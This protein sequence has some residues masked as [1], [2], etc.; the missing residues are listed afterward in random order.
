MNCY[1]IRNI[2]KIFIFIFFICFLTKVY[3]QVDPTIPLPQ[4]NLQNKLINPIIN[5][6]PFIEQK[7]PKSVSPKTPAQDKALPSNEKQEPIKEEAQDEVLDEE[8]KRGGTNKR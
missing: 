1:F 5:E 4:R 7:V 6:N 2:L 8:E 3:P